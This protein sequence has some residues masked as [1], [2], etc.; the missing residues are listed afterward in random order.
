MVLKFHEST[1]IKGDK[2]QENPFHENFVLL[3]SL[4][5]H[6]LKTVLF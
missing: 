4:D 2:I 5:E 1:Y 3:H 6:A